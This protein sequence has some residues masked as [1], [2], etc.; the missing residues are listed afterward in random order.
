MNSFKE[1]V[2]VQFWKLVVLFKGKQE[3]R[4]LRFLSCKARTFLQS[5][6]RPQTR[7]SARIGNVF[8][9]VGSWRKIETFKQW[10]WNVR[11]RFHHMGWPPAFV[12]P[13]HGAVIGEKLSHSGRVC[14]CL[15]SFRISVVFMYLR[16][17]QSRGTKSV[18]SRF[19]RFNVS[20]W[21][22]WLRGW[23][24][25]P[26]PHSANVSYWFCK[27]PKALKQRQERIFQSVFNHFSFSFLGPQ[28]VSQKDP[29]RA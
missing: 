19:W 16:T 10:R 22:G 28:F 25:T 7:T 18:P 27:K 6:S 21:F 20:D 12:L 24:W 3:E 13:R 5:R 15:G 14:L 11:R 9:T 4:L 8:Q 23:I 26:L 2:V 1:N 17:E 29:R